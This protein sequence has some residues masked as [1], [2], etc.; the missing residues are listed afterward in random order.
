MC[1]CSKEHNVTTKT[2]VTAAIM[3]KL[4]HCQSLI[5]G[6]SFVNMPLQCWSYH[7]VHLLRFSYGCWNVAVR[8]F[9]WYQNILSFNENKFTFN[10]H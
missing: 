4:G 10:L 5:A 9:M 7:F 8:P 6:R 2:S 3:T 1:I